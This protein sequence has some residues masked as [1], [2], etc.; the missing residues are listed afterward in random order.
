MPQLFIVTDI[1]GTG[2]HVGIK[3]Q[4][5]AGGILE[6]TV[7]ID[8]VVY[9]SGIL[10]SVERDVHKTHLMRQHHQR[11]LGTRHYAAASSLYLMYEQRVR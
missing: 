8:K 11:Q 10:D 7:T 9:I 6:I 4:L 1:I 3:L 5:Y 2:H